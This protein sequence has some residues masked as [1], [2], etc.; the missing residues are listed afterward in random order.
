MG[1]PKINKLT[2]FCKKIN[3]HY[4]Y[5]YKYENERFLQL[6]KLRYNVWNTE[7][8]YDQ[9]CNDLFNDV[10]KVRIQMALQL[11]KKNFLYRSCNSNKTYEISAEPNEIDCNCTRA[12]MFTK[13]GISNDPCHHV[14][15]VRAFLHL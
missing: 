14:K 6:D 15:E 13:T 8:I 11:D 2:I 4:Y 1:R 10:D 5:V 7:L 9:I 3:E 12:N